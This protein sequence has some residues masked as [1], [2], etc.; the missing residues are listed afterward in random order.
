MV[1]AIS[2]PVQTQFVAALEPGGKRLDLHGFFSAT[3]AL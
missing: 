2:L 1:A 3:A